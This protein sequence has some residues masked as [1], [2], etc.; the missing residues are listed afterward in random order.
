M[1]DYGEKPS[2]LGGDEDLNT[3]ADV[4]VSLPVDS[5][6]IAVHPDIR[7]IIEE[8]EELGGAAAPGSPANSPVI[9][10]RRDRRAL[11]KFRETSRHS[12]PLRGPGS[13]WS[14]DVGE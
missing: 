9:N 13:G 11:K 7:R 4:S 2:G 3:S 10:R 6:G 8:D 12:R 5:V 14:P 1:L